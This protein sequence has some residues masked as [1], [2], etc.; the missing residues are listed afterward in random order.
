MKILITGVAGLLG[1]RLADWI[2]ENTDNEV[3]GID[4]LSGG[5]LNNVNPKV[6]FHNF[7]LLDYKKVDSVFEES[8]IDIVYH[9][10]AYAAEGLSPFIRRYNYENNLLASVNL[11]NSSIKFGVD[12]FVF[13]SSMS[14]Y[15]NKHEPPFSE[16]YNNTPLTHMPWRNSQ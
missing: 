16:I 9:F 7:N 5:Y 8:N 1:S 12:R 3:I 4:D 10:A 15:G 2:I 11:I 14:V 6:K 13:A